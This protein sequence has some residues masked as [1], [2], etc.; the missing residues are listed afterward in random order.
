MRGEAVGRC[1][2]GSCVASPDWEVFLA[3]EL[4]TETLRVTNVPTSG[5]YTA[6]LHTYIYTAP[7]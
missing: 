4:A 2:E 7:F 3:R 6:T 5:I 1:E